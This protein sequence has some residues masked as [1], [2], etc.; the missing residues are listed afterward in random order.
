MPDTHT[1]PKQWGVDRPFWYAW[2]D[3]QAVPVSIR[4][5]VAQADAWERREDGRVGAT[6]IGADGSRT[7]GV[8]PKLAWRLF[9]STVF[10]GM[11]HGMTFE[12]PPVLWETLVFRGSLAIDRSMLRYSSRAD[13]EAGHEATVRYVQ[14]AMRRGIPLEELDWE[15]EYDVDTQPTRQEDE[16]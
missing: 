6:S 3:G 1:T 11:D 10:L 16:P 12:G 15:V 14:D 7:D 4:D 2:R 8:D 13:A 9:V 5:Y